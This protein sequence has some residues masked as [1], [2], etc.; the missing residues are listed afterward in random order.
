MAVIKALPAQTMTFTDNGTALVEGDVVEVTGDMQAEKVAD[1]TVEPDG[2]VVV[3]SDEFG[4]AT[5]LLNRPVLEMTAGSG[6]ITAG[7]EVKADTGGQ[8][9][10]D[11]GGTGVA[12]GTAIKGAS[13]DKKGL[14]AV[15]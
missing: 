4:Y 7:D 10:V 6:G 12:L 11:H 2:V 8:K 14:V 13:A 15:K 3:G 9:V 1:G 5:V